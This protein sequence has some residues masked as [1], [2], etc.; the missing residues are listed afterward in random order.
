MAPPFWYKLAGFGL[1]DAYGAIP[2][3]LAV[4][5]ALAAASANWAG[6]IPCDGEVITLAAWKA[7]AVLSAYADTIPCIG[8]V[9]TLAAWKALAALLSVRTGLRCT[10]PG[11]GG[12]WFIIGHPWPARPRG[13][14]AGKVA[15]RT[16]RRDFS[17]QTR[18][19]LEVAAGGYATTVSRP[20]VRVVRAC[21]KGKFLLCLLSRGYSCQEVDK[22]LFDTPLGG[23]FHTTL[24]ARTA[25]W[26]TPA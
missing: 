2:L 11:S 25:G 3:A 15:L 5:S 19:I 1:E 12:G 26:R 9:I 13:F 10:S 8:E 22:I 20:R 17:Y 24:S 23:T 14:I 21:E 7:R 4:L 6:S 18:A 16:Y